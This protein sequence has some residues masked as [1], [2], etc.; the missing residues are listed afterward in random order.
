V[1][2]LLLL[3]NH[4]NSIYNGILNYLK[5]FSPAKSSNDFL[6]YLMQEHVSIPRRIHPCPFYSSLDPNFLTTALSNLKAQG[7]SVRFS[8]FSPVEGLCLTLFS[9]SILLSTPERTVLLCF[10]DEFFLFQDFV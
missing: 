2:L 7:E 8:C 1:L 4:L 9:H 6:A 5:N 3:G 10:H